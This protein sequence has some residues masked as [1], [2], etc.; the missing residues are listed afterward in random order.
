MKIQLLDRAKK[1]KIV[2]QLEEFGIEKISELLVHTGTD[3]IR[4]YSGSLSN[5]E[6]LSLWRILP[7]E[8]IGLY[9]AREFADKSGIKGIRLS[10]D[11]V[12]LWKNQISRKIFILNEKQEIEWFKGKNI[13]LDEEQKKLYQGFSGFFL[14]KSADEKDFL[15]SGK[16]T[17]E[18]LYSFLPK[19]RRR[20]GKTI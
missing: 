6:I 7:F 2:E 9:V 14:I 11:G 17:G 8:G 3:R 4:A 12:H 13:D 15:G 16:I 1:K 5:E 10:T 18:M 19:E 20:K